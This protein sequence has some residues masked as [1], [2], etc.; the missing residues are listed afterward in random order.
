[1]Y[2]VEPNFTVQESLVNVTL[3]ENSEEASSSPCPLIS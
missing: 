1:M 2:S 3:I